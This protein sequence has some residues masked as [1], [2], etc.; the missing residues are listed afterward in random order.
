M[1]SL[2]SFSFL[3]LARQEPPGLVALRLVRVVAREHQQ[4]VAFGVGQIHRQTVAEHGS[5]AIRF[6]RGGRNRSPSAATPRSAVLR[7]RVA[8]V[9]MGR[10][11]RRVRRAALQLPWIRRARARG[12]VRASMKAPRRSLC[13]ELSL[14]RRR[15]RDR[16]YGNA[17]ADAGQFPQAHPPSRRRHY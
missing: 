12:Q 2:P 8:M 5:Q 4:R 3:L 16:P 17:P 7:L 14:R 1:C 9:S 11:G 15:R 13:P 6:R 10:E